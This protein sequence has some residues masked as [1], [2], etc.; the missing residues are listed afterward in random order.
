MYFLQAD[1]LSIVRNR[2]PIKQ[3]CDSPIA[4]MYNVPCDKVGLA[5]G[6]NRYYAAIL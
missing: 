4:I 1:A 5:R 2:Q 3:E 6:Q